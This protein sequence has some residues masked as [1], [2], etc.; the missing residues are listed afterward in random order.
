MNWMK[1]VM[2]YGDKVSRVNFESF[3]GKKVYNE[4]MTLG[5]Q[6]KNV[7]GVMEI[8]NKV[9]EKYQ[10]H[11]K[12]VREFSEKEGDTEYTK[13][14][15]WYSVHR[16][17]SISKIV[18]IGM[19][20]FYILSCILCLFL[21]GALGSIIVFLQDIVLVL[22]PLVCVV[23]TGSKVTEMIFSFVYNSYAKN[24]A[25]VGNEMVGKFRMEINKFGHQIDEMYLNSL[26]PAHREVVLMRRDQER[27]H[28]EMMKKKAAHYEEMRKIQEK[29]LRE[30]QKIRKTQEKLLEIERDREARYSR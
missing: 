13:Y 24:I 2:S 15:R 8:V 28:Q 9:E 12:V 27:Q 1:R 25:K 11:C 20:I 3:Y 22:F 5:N 4:V 26:E 29:T 7:E 10:S 17:K 6:N 23:F 21:Q 30:Q 14:K 18:F 19:L 16:C